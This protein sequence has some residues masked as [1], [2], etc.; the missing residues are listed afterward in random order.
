MY[1]KKCYICGTEF[2]LDE[3]GDVC[4]RCGW[5]YLGWEKELNPDERDDANLTTI[6]KAKENY[7]KGLNIWG[8]PL[9]K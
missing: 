4:P 7:A 6:R 1:I 3:Y 2:D 8:E 5:Y 9:E